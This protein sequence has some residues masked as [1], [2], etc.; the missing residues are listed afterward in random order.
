LTT[1]ESL[2][3]K[4][5]TV[6]TTVAIDD[7][8]IVLPLGFSVG[9]AYQNNGML[10]T[11][12]VGVQQWSDF[13]LLGVHPA[14]MQNSMRA[15]IGVEWL[16]GKEFVET[17]AQQIGYRLGAYARQ[18]NVKL[19]G[20]SINEYFATAGIGLPLGNDARLNIGLEY[21]VRGTTSAQLVKNNILRLTLS[22]SAG[23][24][25]FLPSEIE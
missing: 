4:L 12:D 2:V 13:T 21:G 17:Y 11:G 3:R 14:E 1:N 7:N 8:S 23:D 25:W 15:G 18:T 9:L 24:Y 22:I 20:T 16:P 5:S 19:Y 10:Y 6:D